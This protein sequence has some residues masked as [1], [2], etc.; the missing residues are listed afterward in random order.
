MS[1][2]IRSLETGFDK[3]L[4]HCQ[5][6][7]TDKRRIDVQLTPEGRK[8]Y[9]DFRNTR[10]AKTRDMLQFLSPADRR[11]FVRICRLI[12]EHQESARSAPLTPPADQS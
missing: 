4:I 9:H 8:T 10:L 2:I 7:V 3:P 6:N 11:E 5:L 1:R 12:R